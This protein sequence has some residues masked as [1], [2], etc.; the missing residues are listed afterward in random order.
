M[1]KSTARLDG[2]ATEKLRDNSTDESSYSAE[3]EQLF[4]ALKAISSDL[5][6]MLTRA[7][8]DDAL[9]QCR[10]DKTS[11]FLQEIH[12]NLHTLARL[13]AG[14][15][16]Y[17]WFYEH[18]EAQIMAFVQVAMRN[19]RT[20]KHAAV[21]LPKVQSHATRYQRLQQ[22]LAV[23]HDYERRLKDN[24]YKAQAEAQ[25]S[26]EHHQVIAC[27]QRLI[28]CQQAIEKIERQLEV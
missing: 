23:H 15:E 3:I 6:P 12:D 9:F 1:A 22:E 5:P 14:H 21:S 16:R 4:S 8:F 10:S 26:G 18:C 17:Q 25:I 13:T 27:Q 20:A 28:R 7:L 19:G 24:L 2:N 11:D